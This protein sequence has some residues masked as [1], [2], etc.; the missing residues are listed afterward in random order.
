MAFA[1]GIPR[2]R[3]AHGARRAII[4]QLKQYN[5]RKVRVDHNSDGHC[6][7]WAL[8]FFS[9]EIDRD[10]CCEEANGNL[11][12]PIVTKRTDI[13]E[14][15]VDF[16]DE[17]SKIFLSVTRCDDV[18]RC[19]AFTSASHD[20]REAL[21][22][23]AEAAYSITDEN[24]ADDMTNAILCVLHAAGNA[25]KRT[26]MQLPLSSPLSSVFDFAIDCTAGGGGNTAGLIRSKS[27]KAVVSFEAHAKRANN[28]KHNLDILFAGKDIQIGSLQRDSTKVSWQVIEGDF[29]QSLLN[30]DEGTPI[31]V[32]SDSSAINWRSVVLD[33][34]MFDPPW[35][36]LNYM[37]SMESQGIVASGTIKAPPITPVASCITTSSDSSVHGMVLKDAATCSDMSSTSIGLVNDY[38]LIPT[39][40]TST[41]E[42]HEQPESI[43]LKQLWLSHV[44]AHEFTFG[45]LAKRVKVAAVKVPSSF[46]ARAFFQVITR[47]S[48]HWVKSPV[49]RTPRKSCPE[50]SSASIA[51][52]QAHSN[53]EGNLDKVTDVL[54]VSADSATTARKC[55]SSVLPVVDKSNSPSTIL[56]DN[57]P[58]PF[59]LQ[60][61][62][63]TALL[64]V[65][66]PPFFQNS[67]LPFLMR[68]LAAF[69]DERGNEFHP[70]FYDWEKD[71]WIS[72][73][74]WKCS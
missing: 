29:S 36:G 1:S 35:G 2:F 33:A 6:R 39:A 47:P 11:Y 44:L 58:H 42:G 8:L 57:R 37:Q 59:R 22:L 41:I 73:R 14:N 64:I 69:D 31:D 55:S 30:T 15:A 56:L 27:F 38:N 18:R 28:L 21:R 26:S 24:T 9:A 43:C 46:D 13:K 50:S 23:D 51:C 19:H 17:T 3:A 12:I 52:S 70:Q 71:I 20:E 7:G 61:G 4:T 10:K 34:I 72:A 25:V 53:I 32:K 62:A 45:M 40:L 60:M 49:N 66:Y 63:R 67:D 16:D 65:A 5:V 54:P 48:I 68:A 74:R